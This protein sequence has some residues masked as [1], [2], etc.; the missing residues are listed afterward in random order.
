MMH[1]E[2]TD[3][4]QNISAVERETG[5]S[6]DVLRM[7]ESRYAF[8]KPAR[9]DNGERQYS[10]ADVAK[11]RAIK[12]VMA[13][14]MRP[15]RLIDGSPEKVTGLADAR[16]ESRGEPAAPALERDVIALLQN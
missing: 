3:V 7:W 8:P 13:V 11:L 16:V 14:G 1:A 12:R 9:D 15:G 10:I 5:L 6:K 2:L 4:S